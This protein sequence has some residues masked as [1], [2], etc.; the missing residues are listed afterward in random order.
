MV[1][2]C[3]ECGHW[4][5]IK[6]TGQFD[7][8]KII[9]ITVCECINPPR[10]LCDKGMDGIPGWCPEMIRMAI[11]PEEDG[12]LADLGGLWNKLYEKLGEDIKTNEHVKIEELISWMDE[13][14]KKLPSIL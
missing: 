12:Y 14:Q 9:T 11:T 1:E 4:G 3:F 2:N 7:P 8:N 5:L 13:E 6:L 10:I